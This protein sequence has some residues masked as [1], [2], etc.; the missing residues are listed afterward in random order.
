[1]F[2]R[3]R[4]YSMEDLQVLEEAEYQPEL[5]RKNELI[6]NNEQIE[7]V[8]KESDEILPE[9][10]VYRKRIRL[11]N[12]RFLLTVQTGACVLALLAAIGLRLFGGV[13]YE[14]VRQWYL[15]TAYA[16][17]TVRVTKEDL[18]KMFGDDTASVATDTQTVQ[19]GAGIQNTALAVTY[20]KNREGPVTL[21][22]LLRKPV[23]NGTITSAFG[24]RNGVFH[25]GIDIGAAEDTPIIA[26]L[27]GTVKEVGKNDSY[28]N[29]IVL[30]HGSGIE[31]RYAHCSSI[32]V[33][34]GEHVN[35][36]AEIAKMGSSGDA[37]GTHLHL[38]LL[39]NGVP[40]D[41]QTVLQG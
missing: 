32:T 35:M 8:P 28:G 16:S 23:E 15:G 31:T 26:C 37:T 33:K 40:Y 24:E 38:E 6:D 18:L 14:T 41:P 9:D 34:Q 30:D 3:N 5:R 22:V 36:G 1:M 39:I 4:S 13:V 12:G 19:T 17:I 2:K 11:Q 21:S 10:G 7:T 27:T 29:Y 25:Q 20:G